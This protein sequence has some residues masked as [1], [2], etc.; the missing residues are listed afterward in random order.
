MSNSILCARRTLLT[1]CTV[2]GFQHSHRT[3]RIHASTAPRTH[4]RC[5]P[6]RTHTQ[7]KKQARKTPARTPLDSNN[8]LYIHTAC[9]ASTITQFVHTI[10]ATCRCCS[11]R[12][13]KRRR[14][15]AAVIIVRRKQRQQTISLAASSSATNLTVIAHTYA[16]DRSRDA[17]RTLHRTGTNTVRVWYC[18]YAMQATPPEQRWLDFESDRIPICIIC[19]WINRTTAIGFVLLDI[20]MFLRIAIS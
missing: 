7:P 6:T 13:H 15:Y 10:Q 2:S 5:T 16:H 17:A 4:W 12:R 8:I 14:R 11:R 19:I 20:Y 3:N 9:A 18:V 1:S